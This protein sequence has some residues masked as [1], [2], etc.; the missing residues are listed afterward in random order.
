MTIEKYI[1][2]IG[3]GRVARPKP[4]WS[5]LKF[6]FV[7]FSA[8]LSNIGFSLSELFKTAPFYKSSGPDEGA[9]MWLRK[10]LENVEIMLILSQYF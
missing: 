4:V 1:I 10:I 5:G 7:M 6:D 3:M 8:L 9:F 2:N